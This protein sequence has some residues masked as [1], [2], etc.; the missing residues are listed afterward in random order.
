MNLSENDIYEETWRT[1][2]FLGKGKGEAAGREGRA[3]VVRGVLC[4][5]LVS[6]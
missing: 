3:S 6:L 1:R 4:F 2:W 5:V